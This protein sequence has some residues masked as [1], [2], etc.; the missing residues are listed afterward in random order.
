MNMVAI[1]V[2]MAMSGSVTQLP[3]CSISEDFE[4][5]LH[6]ML[7]T[8]MSAINSDMPERDAHKNFGNGDYRLLGFGDISGLVVPTADQLTATQFCEEGVR[9]LPGMTDSFESR[10][11]RELVETIR[12]YV[13]RYNAAMVQLL[14]CALYK[15]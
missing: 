2:A 3:D 15:E 6:G 14:R 10:E 1:L 9:V 8:E 12:E 13:R 4:T 11:H 5:S 7:K